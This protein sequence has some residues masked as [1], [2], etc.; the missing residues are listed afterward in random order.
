MFWDKTTETL[1]GEKLKTLQ[2][3]RLKQTIRQSQHVGFYKRR[4][5]DA[6]VRPEDIRTLDDIKKI[7][8]PKNRT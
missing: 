1:K 2:V 4:L 8:L 5:A 3:R 6:K 7:P